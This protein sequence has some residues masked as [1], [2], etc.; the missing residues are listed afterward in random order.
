MSKTITIATL[1][2]KGGA[3]KTSTAVNLGGVLHESGR[4]PILIDLDPQESASYWARQ[5]GNKFPYPVIPLKV[6]QA[7]QF[8]AKIEQLI[9]DHQADTVLFDCPPALAD[10]A[11][12]AAL[13][14][15]IALIPVSPSPLDIWAAEKAIETIKE[16]RQ[17]RKGLPK[18][19]I[20]PSRLVPN[21]VL[22]REIK[23][24]LKQFNEPIAPAITMRVAIAEACIAGLPINLY[25]PESPSHKEFQ[26]LMKFV[27][28]N[29]RK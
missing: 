21:T 5:G 2:L 23:G 29:L 19:A 8:K 10:E 4:K 7:K 24:S 3:G 16:A 28:T 22:A 20:V 12:I 17:E 14:S 11:L 6:G 9:K 18:V 25:Q 27:N 26:A 13:L 1:N 15:D